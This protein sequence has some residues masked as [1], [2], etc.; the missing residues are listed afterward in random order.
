MNMLQ[1]RYD[2]IE[3]QITRWMA[4]YGLT[5]LRISLGV[6]FFW[7]GFLKFFPDMSPAQDLAARTIEVLTFGVVK[8]ELSL[9]VLAVWECLIGLGFLT[10]KFMR[11]TLVLL[12]AQ[13]MGTLSP[14][15]L[16][17]VETFVGVP[18]MPTMEGQYIIKNI[19]FISAGIVL[20]ATIRGG[21]LVD[22]P[23]KVLRT[24]EIR[25]QTDARFKTGELP[26]SI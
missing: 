26:R 24:Q 9:P 7:F 8:P 17:P 23:R 3:R 14:L 20:G 19:V 11:L 4:L 22:D 2:R 16:F 1:H 21:R 6:V 25:L 12:F 15:L 5:C 10:G 13:M 18:F